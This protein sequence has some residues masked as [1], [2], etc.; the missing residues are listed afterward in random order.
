MVVMPA[1]PVDAPVALMHVASAAVSAMQRHSV[2]RGGVAGFYRLIN[3]NG[4][5]FLC[6]VLKCSGVL[7][8][9]P[10]GRLSNRVIVLSEPV[11]VDGY[12]AYT[13]DPV[14][15]AESARVGDLVSALAEWRADAIG[16]P[17]NKR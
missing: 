17:K 2:T 15:L 12:T 6:M 7:A 5:T 13:C 11:D 3:E 8:A 1:E 10:M 14:L 9:V 4:L 16:L